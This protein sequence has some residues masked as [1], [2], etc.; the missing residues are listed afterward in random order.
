MKGYQQLQAIA[1]C[2]HQNV[3]LQTEN[4]Y[5]QQLIRQV[6]RTLECTHTLAESL[7]KAHIWLLKIAAC[8]RYP[9]S[10]YDDEA[11]NALTSQIVEKEMT[12]LLELFQKQAK[13]DRV[14]FALYSAVSYRWQLYGKDLL[15]CYD[16]HGLPPDNLHLESLFNRLRRRQR[17]ISSRK[18]TKELRAFGQYQVLFLAESQ[19]DLLDQIRCVPLAEYQKHRRLLAKAEIPRLFLHRLHRNPRKAIQLLLSR[20]IDRQAKLSRS[21]QFPVQLPRLC[22]V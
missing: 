4:T 15:H 22:N 8:L 21:F 14:L 9:P 1:E 7:Q 13:G 12:A 6:D 20:Y 10:S 17:R 5:F 11:L 19:A 2:L 18:S 3:G 16:I